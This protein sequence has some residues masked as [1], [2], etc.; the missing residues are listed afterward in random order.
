M[1]LYLKSVL[2]LRMCYISVV[3]QQ[4]SYQRATL[5]PSPDQG[6]GRGQEWIY[7]KPALRAAEASAVA[8]INKYKTMNLV[9]EP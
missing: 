2:L 1:R 6:G 7:K 9:N 3:I 8:V 5:R 4:R